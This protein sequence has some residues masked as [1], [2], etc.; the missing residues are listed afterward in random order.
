MFERL[1]N[2]DWIGIY[3]DKQTKDDVIESCMVG[4][5]I[6]AM[7]HEYNELKDYDY[8]CYMDSKLELVSETFVEEFIV[9]YFIEQNYALLLRE[10]WYI[11]NNVWNEYNDSMMYHHRYR[12]ESEKYQEYIKNQVNNGLSDITEHH[13]ATGLL[14]RNM[15]HEK[16]IDLNTT[17]YE[18]IQQCGIQCQISFFFVKQLFDGYIHSFTDNPFV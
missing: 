13:C 6:K 11:H 17:W 10:H 3:H 18:H 1:Q 8:L 9:K 16:M 2:T 5:H 14:I 4:K 15:K 12:L 7:P